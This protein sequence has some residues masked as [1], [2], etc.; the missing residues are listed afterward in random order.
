MT[1]SSPAMMAESMRVSARGIFPLV[2]QRSVILAGHE[3]GRRPRARPG[4]LPD[5]GAPGTP[6]WRPGVCLVGCCHHVA[7]REARLGLAG[8]RPLQQARP[9]A[10]VQSGGAKSGAWFVGAVVALSPAGSA[11]ALVTVARGRPSGPAAVESGEALGDEGALSSG[12]LVGPL[13]HL[14]PVGRERDA[15][16]GR[17]DSPIRHSA[18]GIDCPHGPRSVVS[19]AASWRSCLPCGAADDTRCGAYSPRR[20]RISR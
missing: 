4:R 3:D 13:A 19:V 1:A 18:P 11:L 15:V 2:R 14:K 20:R 7:A 12:D 9:A 8:G 10:R 6:A 16:A 17:V 5:G